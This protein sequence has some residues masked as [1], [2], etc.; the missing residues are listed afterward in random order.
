M[1]KG[2]KEKLIYISLR[3]ASKSCDYTQEYLSLRARQGKLKSVKFGKNWIT[4]KEWLTEYIKKSKEYNNTHN[5]KDR[6]VGSFKKEEIQ[7]QAPAPPVS[8]NA[9]VKKIKIIKVPQNLPIKKEPKLRLGFAAALITVLFLAG[10]IFSQ[11]LFFKKI[12]ENTFLS[13]QETSLSLETTQANINSK[14][15]TADLQEKFKEYLG[16]ILNAT[17]IHLTVIENRVNSLGKFFK[18][19]LLKEN[20]KEAEIIFFLDEKSQTVR[21]KIKNLIFQ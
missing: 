16:I 14:I 2:G 11:R 4:T 6:K 7:S 17:K 18:K 10:G 3:E 20:K 9:E 12:I 5:I 8:R 19:N 1:K 13:A 21:E 15:L